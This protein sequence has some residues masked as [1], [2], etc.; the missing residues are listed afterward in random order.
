MATAFT[1]WLLKYAATS[2][3]MV[4]VVVELS[5]FLRGFVMV[6]TIHFS[7]YKIDFHRTV[8]FEGGAVRKDLILCGVGKT[9]KV[10]FECL[11]CV[12]RFFYKT[13]YHDSFGQGLPS[14]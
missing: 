11:K 8:C 6:S 3:A 12:N 4:V 10:C 5:R 1:C 7:C 13:I 9:L 14:L 2:S